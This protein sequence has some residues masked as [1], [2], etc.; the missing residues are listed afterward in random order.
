MIVHTMLTLN[1]THPEATHW[2]GKTT[3]S[4]NKWLMITL[5]PSVNIFNKLPEGGPT[6]HI[7]GVLP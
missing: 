1:Y 3:H 2:N 7:Y 4:M 5:I 6:C